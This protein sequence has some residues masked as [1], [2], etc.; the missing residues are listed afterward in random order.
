MLF[1]VCVCGSLARA[2]RTRWGGSLKETV[3]FLVCERCSHVGAVRTRQGKSIA[4]YTYP[5][6]T[7]RLPE[8]HPWRWWTPYIPRSP[9]QDSGWHWLAWPWSRG[10][11]DKDR[12]DSTVPSSGWAQ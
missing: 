7:P 8:S 3:P 9:S 6:G 10:L 5:T 11:E 2:A 4:Y 1:H 12:P